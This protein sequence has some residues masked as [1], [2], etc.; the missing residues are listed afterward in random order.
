MIY[1]PKTLYNLIKVYI[2]R[3]DIPLNEI[4][5]DDIAYGICNTGDLFDELAPFSFYYGASRGCFVPLGAENNYVFKFD[6]NH[7]SE[8]Y[9]EQEVS[10]YK[11]AEEEGLAFV[12]AK[13]EFYD[14]LPNSV[15]LYKQRKVD[16]ISINE[17]NNALD[18]ESIK[19]IAHTINTYNQNISELP[20]QWCQKFQEVYGEDTFINFLNFCAE[21]G[22]NDLHDRNVGYDTN[23]NP[24][25]FD[26]AGF[27]E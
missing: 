16:R 8:Q 21:Q 13:I 23:G 11:A 22:V 6:L 12:F 9:C 10:I 14:E 19:N 2:D 25:V 3:Y 5:Y 1:T 17:D 15:A 27:F 26:Y 7:V 4:D 20:F 18:K 24:I